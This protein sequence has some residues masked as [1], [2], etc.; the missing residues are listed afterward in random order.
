MEQWVPEGT[1][2]TLVMNIQK[3]VG[4]MYQLKTDSQEIL[5]GRSL[6]NFWN[7]CVQDY[8]VFTEVSDTN[9]PVVQYSS[10]ISRDKADVFI[11]NLVSE[12]FY[13][14]VTAQNK[15]Q[16]I[17]RV[18]SQVS[19]SLLEYVHMHDGYPSENG[20]LKMVRYI[21]KMVVEGTVHVQDDFSKKDNLVSNLVPN[22]EILIPNY[23][24]PDIQ[25]QPMLARIQEKITYDEAEEEFGELP[26]WKYVQKGRMNAWNQEDVEFKQTFEGILDEDEVQI[27]RFWWPVK[28]NK[29][30]TKGFNIMVNGVLLFAPGTVIPY[31]DGFY[32][33]SKGIF[34]EFAKPEFYWGNSMPNKVRE[35]KKWIDAWKALLRFKAKLNVL[36]PLLSKNGLFIDEE[37][38]LPSK[39]TAVTEETDIR[40]IEGV[41]EPVTQSDVAMLQMAEGEI[42]RGTMSPRTAGQ[43]AEK[44]QTAREVVIQEANAQKLLDVFGLRVAF[45]V[46][47]RTY[48]ILSRAY[49]FLPRST[50]K[51]I[52]IPEQSLPDGRVGTLEVIFEKMPDMTEQEQ[53]DQSLQI[54]QEEQSAL[55]AGE[56]KRMVYINPEY[57]KE[58]DLYVKAEAGSNFLN[59]DVIER[60]RYR[61]DFM[62]VYSKRPDLFNQQTAARRFVQNNRDAEDLLIQESR[63]IQQESQE[64]QPVM[65]EEQ[66]VPATPL[67][68]ATPAL[69][70][71]QPV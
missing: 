9:D 48:M 34:T 32:P 12:M 42:D 56:P 36:P 18:M 41:A 37:I 45:L 52:A 16:K 4:R 2:K 51:K 5:G 68:G 23:W 30:K 44:R 62:N 49:Q 63:Q 57:V 20:H 66:A 17:D 8:A 50:I 10:S 35:D 7:D 11:A 47:A 69:A 3:H 64:E 1:E 24:Q 46:M 19:R 71:L 22:E 60:Q 67:Q 31:R 25:K 38:I 29:K 21:H 40:K 61:E 54:R 33:I 53:L 27:V 70:E 59:R 6:Q 26:N 58:L 14:S 13:P 65:Q 55:Q 15:D 39:I 28:K 43:M